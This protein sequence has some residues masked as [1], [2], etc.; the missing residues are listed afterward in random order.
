MCKI[1]IGEELYWS[2]LYS[3]P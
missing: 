1:G 2:T 3:M